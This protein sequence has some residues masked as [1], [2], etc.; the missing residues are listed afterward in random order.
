MFGVLKKWV[1]DNG[2]AFPRVKVTVPKTDG[3][4]KADHLGT[5]CVT[6]RQTK[7][8]KAKNKVRSSVNV[9]SQ[10]DRLIQRL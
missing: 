7:K 9:L 1:A 6:Q 3:S 4:N 8:K 10:H 2:G 5:W